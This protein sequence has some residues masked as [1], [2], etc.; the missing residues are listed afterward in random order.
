MPVVWSGGN[1]KSASA[2]GWRAALVI[3]FSIFFAQ[4][5]VA[6]AKAKAHAKSPEP[7]R[8]EISFPKRMSAA[9]LDGRLLLVVSTDN[10]K[11]PRF[12]VSDQPGTQQMFGV[13]VDGMK[14]GEPVAVDATALGYPLDSIQQIP[15][16]DYY[17]Q[18]ALNVYTTFHRA[19]GYVVK[20]PMDEGEGQQWNRKPGN[21][22]S[23]PERVHLDPAAGGVIRVA[24]TEKIP[25]IEPP[26]DTEYIK[27]LRIQS[28]LLTKFWGRP[29]YLGAL[30]LLPAGWAEHP[31]ARYPLMVFQGH[32]SSGI[33]WFRTE[34]PKP[35]LKGRERLLAEYGY[36]LYQDWTS[37]RLPRM[38]IMEI[39]HANPYYDDSYAVNSANVGPYGDAILHE[40][41]PAVEKKFR[42]IGQ[43]WA[44]ALYGGSTGGWE[45]LGDQIFYPDDFN[46]AWGMCPDPVD[47]RAYQI[48]NI[49]DDKNALWLEGPWSR[50]PRPAVRRPDGTVVTTM[51]RENRRELVLGT[52]GRSE[53]QF[54][55]WQAVFSPVGGDGYPKPIW[56][57]DTGVIDP[58][59]AEYWKQHY[60]LRH[61]LAR[62][63]K[64]LG[65]KLVGKLH[66]AVGTRD[67]YYL[68]NA[69]RLMQTFLENTNNPY[70]AGYVHYGPHQ[71]HCYSD[72]GNKSNLI[73]WLTIHQRILPKAAKWMTRTAPKGAD[74]TSWK[75]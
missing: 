54:G 9:P 69:V 11:E 74:T 28:Q 2:S 7:M 17:I 25:P 20:L 46:G 51:D 39:Q 68:D 57:P 38:I 72:Q 16:G 40:L 15:A 10:A 14:P 56:D 61:I 67:T 66:I 73:G 63:W 59:V 1:S 47:F 60:D 6:N 32:F 3:F 23:K 27:H 62:D 37:G 42:G 30:V 55:I 24:L 31:N 33:S 41:I 48:V 26:K 29:M 53:D 12:E 70:Y 21:L 35:G 4:T 36:K 75:Y 8:F 34:P 43:G 49:Y 19:D 50:I 64:T 71:P 13:D 52:H 5:A 65:P 22:Y 18:A 45:A 44:R 58:S